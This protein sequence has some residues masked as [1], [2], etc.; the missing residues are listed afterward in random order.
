MDKQNLSFFE[1][2]NRKRIR[3]EPGERLNRNR[4]LVVI[5]KLLKPQLIFLL[6]FFNPNQFCPG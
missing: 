4:N 3:R 6:D 2:R 5:S 1:S